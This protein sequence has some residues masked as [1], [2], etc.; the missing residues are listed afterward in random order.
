MCSNM[1]FTIEPIISESSTNFILWPDN[2]TISNTKY[3]FSAQFEH[4]I[5]IQKKRST[6]SNRQ[7][8]YI[9]KIF[10]AANKLNR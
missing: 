10:V 6:N 3:H 7:K 5:L 8:R 1:V 2:W 4:T 9:S